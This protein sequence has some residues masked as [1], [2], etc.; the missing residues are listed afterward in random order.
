MATRVPSIS[1][2]AFAPTGMSSKLTGA[3]ASTIASPAAARF[4]RTA[5]PFGRSSKGFG[6]GAPIGRESTLSAGLAVSS[7]SGE[8]TATLGRTSR[9]GDSAIGGVRMWSTAFPCV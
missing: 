7:A 3:T 6:V 2:D 5:L 9:S 4:L 1:C 8:G